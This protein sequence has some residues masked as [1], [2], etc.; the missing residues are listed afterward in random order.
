M[1]QIVIVTAC[2]SK[3]GNEIPKLGILV[4]KFVGLNQWTVVSAKHTG[5]TS[6]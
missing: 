5:S 2:L 1:I 3:L 6:H 4:V